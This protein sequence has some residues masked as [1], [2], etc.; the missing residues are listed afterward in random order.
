MAIAMSRLRPE[1]FKQAAFPAYVGVLLL[2]IL[3]EALGFVGGG[4]QRWLDL[5]FIRLQP[6]EL[7]KPVIVLVLRPLLR[8]AAGRARSGAGARSG[9][10]PC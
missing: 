2:L 5:G 6:S 8:A 9:R 10:P 7:M 4:A 3:V 1:R